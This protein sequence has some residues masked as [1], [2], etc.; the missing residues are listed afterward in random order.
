MPKYAKVVGEYVTRGDH[1]GAAYWPYEEEFILDDSV[2][3]LPYARSV[4]QKGLLNDKL[5]ERGIANFKGWRTAQVVEFKETDE[6]V[7]EEETEL[8]KLMAEATRLGCVPENLA[9]YKRPD[10]K[11]N[12]LKRAIEAFKKSRPK[13]EEAARQ[14]R[15]AGVVQDHGYID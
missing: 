10:Y 5:R 7:K 4:I 3:S 6:A 13:R 8:Q 14:A 1:G 2:P 12:A 9:N 11:A 15:Q